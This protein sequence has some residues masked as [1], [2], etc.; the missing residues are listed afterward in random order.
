MVLLIAHLGVSVHLINSQGFQAGSER[1]RVGRH[2]QLSQALGRS[3]HHMAGKQPAIVL[4][5]QH[6][7]LVQH[8]PHL[9]W[10]AKQIFTTYAH[11][12]QECIHESALLVDAVSK[13]N[14]RDISA[15]WQS[16]YGIPIEGP[17]IPTAFP[18]AIVASTQPDRWGN[19]RGR[20]GEERGLT[21]IPLGPVYENI[22]VGSPGM[23]ALTLPPKSW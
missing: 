5:S 16:T 15:P 10:P 2:S 22:L 19:F 6:L 18:L 23:P 20:G 1:E 21:R 9:R 7:L 11:C 3:H 8:S 12:L 13:S 17:C 4:S 14:P